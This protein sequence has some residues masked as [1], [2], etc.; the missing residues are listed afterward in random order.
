MGGLGLFELDPFLSAQKCSWIQQAGD[1]NDKWKLILH[2]L[3]NG[4]R[5]NI[6]KS[7][8]DQSALPVL[9]GILST[10]E[11]FLVGFTKHNENFW[12]SPLYE[13]GAHMVSQRQKIWLTSNFFH[14]QF[15]ELHKEKNFNLKVRD[16][17][18]N[19]DTLVRFQNFCLNTQIPLTRDQFNTL[20]NTCS[21]AKQKYSKKEVNK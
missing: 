5:I 1:L 20:K 18:V 4:N 13:N 14:P 21:M 16:F 6:R 8:I 17:Y 2:F 12:G 15:F 19:K 7:L 9:F 10:S 11:K 3:S